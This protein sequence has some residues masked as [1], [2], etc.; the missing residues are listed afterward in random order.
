MH[1][2]LRDSLLTA[3][4]RHVLG[5]PGGRGAE[6]L[7]VVDL[8]GLVA[9][10]G[11]GGEE[12]TLGSLEVD[13]TVAVT[14]SASGEVA[15]NPAMATG[16]LPDGAFGLVVVGGALSRSVDP[17]GT[18]REAVR[19]CAP[20]GVIVVVEPSTASCWPTVA[21][22]FGALAASSGVHLVDTWVDPRGPH[23]YGVG[24]FRLGPLSAEATVDDTGVPPVLPASSR[25]LQN[26]W[27]TDAPPEVERG[28][29][30]EYYIGLYERVHQWLAPRNYLEIGVST[31]QSL[32]LASC[33][34]I[35]I[36]PAPQLG[37]ALAGN[38]EL[39]EHTS[40]DVFAFTD[41]VASAGPFDLAFIDGMHLIENV[42]TDFMNVERN[43]HPASLVMIDDPCP[44]HPMQAHRTRVSRFWTGDV[45]KIIPILRRWRPDLL[46]VLVDTDPTGTLLVLGVDP[47]NT[48]LWENYDTILDAA[49]G[50]AVV[51]DDIVARVG[52]LDPGDPL[53]ARLLTMLVAARQSADP[54]GAMRRLRQILEGA[55]PRPVVAP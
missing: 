44:A 52:A 53:I 39:L 16:D 47:D 31:G 13:L 17:A 7:A 25:T 28:R 9:V 41:I 14:G 38:H 24:V 55:L 23:H 2:S 10:D 33:D 26:D 49:V 34:A 32:R 51:D 27:P 3:V 36:D 5:G 35:G 40:D 20:E 37:E 46:L 21:G 30:T 6:T 11:P 1:L 4:R 18:W 54:A 42:L 19:L 29:G 48:T 43:C 50:D 12:P 15:G 45:W 8:D 22:G